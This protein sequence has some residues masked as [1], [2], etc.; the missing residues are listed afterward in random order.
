MKSGGSHSDAG[1]E[2]IDGMFAGTERDKISF[3]RILSG[4]PQQR[5]DLGSGGGYEQDL[6]DPNIHEYEVQG[7]GNKV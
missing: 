5:P 7:N 4:L 2:R 3:D 1:D 6:H